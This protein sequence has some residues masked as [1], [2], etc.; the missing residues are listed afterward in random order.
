MS[1]YTHK[2]E[3]EPTLYHVYCETTG[4]LKILTNIDR[5]VGRSIYDIKTITVDEAV[6]IMQ[7][8]GRNVTR[9]WLLA[10]L[11]DKQKANNH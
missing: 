1:K 11:K 7:A 8:D 2:D 10:K 4:S 3:H 9:E 6:K 5:Y